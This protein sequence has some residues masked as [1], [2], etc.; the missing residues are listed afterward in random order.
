MHKIF[1]M[2]RLKEGVSME[3]YKA[4]SRVEGAEKG[5]PSHEISLLGSGKQRPSVV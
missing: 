1:V 4:W 3:Q 5:E 2:Y